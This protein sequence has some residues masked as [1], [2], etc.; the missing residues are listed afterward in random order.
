M[1]HSYRDVECEERHRNCE[2]TEQL[3]EN[4]DICG[5]VEDM[6][7]L[8]ITPGGTD[9]KETASSGDY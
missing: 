6:R 7:S 5:Y 1:V 2:G 8:G 4:L 3:Q 9:D